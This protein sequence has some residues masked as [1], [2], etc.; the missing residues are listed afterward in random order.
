MLSGC[1]KCIE[2][3]DS[4][5]SSFEKTDSKNSS[6]KN[7]KQKNKVIPNCVVCSSKKSR[8]IKEQE[9]SGLLSSLGIKTPLSRI[10]FGSLLL[11]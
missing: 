6:C 10:L 8:F 2:K 1:L 4:K 3:T 9:T 11:L 7:K 5:N